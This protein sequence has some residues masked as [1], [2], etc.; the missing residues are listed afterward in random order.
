MAKP[1]LWTKDFIVVSFLT[2]FTCL[3]FYLFLVITSVYTMDT[4]Q[5]SPSAAGLATGIF[6]I[7]A[8]LSRLFLGKWIELLG[9]R[10]MLAVGLVFYLI[11]MSLYFVVNSYALLLIIRLFQG[12]AFGIVSAT[13]A[14][15]VAN[16]VP[17]VRRGEGMAYFTSISVALS[18]AIGPFIGMFIRQHS[19]YNMIFLVCTI[20]SALS[21]MML[22][23]LSVPE[24][25][26]TEEQRQETKKFKLSGLLAVKAI[27]ISIVASL[28][29]LS[30]SSVLTFL[31]PY[32][33]EINLVESASVFFIVYS[34]AVVICRPVAGQMSD[35]KRENVVVY[36]AFVLFILGLVSVSQ[37]HNGYILLLSAFLLGLGLGTIT[38][39]GQA[40]MVKM[41]PGHQ[42]GLATSTFFSFMDFGLGIGP[43][44]LGIFIPLIGYRGMYL[45]AAIPL[46]AGMF[47]YYLWQ[48]K[49]YFSEISKNPV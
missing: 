5:S 24:V 46:L 4:F 15:I 35:K 19:S 9:R 8:L 49:K 14:A 31:S 11:M 22:F 32:S 26:L 43:Y 17:V 28:I 7:G 33:Q 25:N 44:V 21:L 34:I 13:A 2:F 1:R 41:V 39:I 40:I 12:A 16:I 38:S 42:T 27:P 48:G 45:I 23:M 10:R 6:V 37:A 30:Y 29:F 20:F 36:P 47:L 3:S 18:A